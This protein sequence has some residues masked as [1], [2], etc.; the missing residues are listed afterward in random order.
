VG[1]L[2]GDIDGDGTVTAADVAAVKSKIYKPVTATDFL[3]DLDTSGFSTIA[4][5][6]VATAQLGNILN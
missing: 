5:Q 2:Y 3:F 1:N 6:R 4:D